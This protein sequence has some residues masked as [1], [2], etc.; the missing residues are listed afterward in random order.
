MEFATALKE[1]LSNLDKQQQIIQKRR[2]YVMEFFEVFGVPQNGHANASK[3]DQ[4]KHVLREL[5]KEKKAYHITDIESEFTLRG[6]EFNKGLI[7]QVLNS[8]R[9]DGIIIA[10]RI[11]KSN[12][13]YYYMNAEAMEG[14]GIS[15]EYLPMPNKFIDNIELM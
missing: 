8:L 11:N 10:V 5:V 9:E 3:S 15:D 4:Y 1:E 7:H 14:E 12:Q 6:F 13:K 2:K